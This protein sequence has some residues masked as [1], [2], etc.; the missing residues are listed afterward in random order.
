MVLVRRSIFK[1]FVFYGRV[2]L[3]LLE[4]DSRWII[5]VLFAIILIILGMRASTVLN[6]SIFQF[7]WFGWMQ[8]VYD[9]FWIFGSGCFSSFDNWNSCRSRYQSFVII[10]G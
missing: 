10:F 1:C 5:R 2:G 9:L 6:G 8:V 7:V 4:S 3:L